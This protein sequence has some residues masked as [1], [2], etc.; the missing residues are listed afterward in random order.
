[1]RPRYDLGVTTAR[2]HYVIG[3]GNAMRLDAFESRNAGLGEDEDCDLFNISQNPSFGGCK[4]SHQMPA[5]MTHTS[6]TLFGSQRQ[7]FV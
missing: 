1:M 7:G 2:G 6:N 5:L 3:A 4:P